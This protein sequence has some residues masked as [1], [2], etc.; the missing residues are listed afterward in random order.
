MPDQLQWLKPLEPFTCVTPVNEK[1]WQEVCMLCGESKD[2]DSV[3][4]AAR[5][6]G[7]K[8]L[9]VENAYPD[10]DQAS[11]A[12]YWPKAFPLPHTDVYRVHFFASE[13]GESFPAQAQREYLG[14]AVVSRPLGRLVRALMKPPPCLRST[15]G[16]DIAGSCSHC[17]RKLPGGAAFEGTVT[18]GV[19]NVELFGVEYVVEGVP[20]C[21]QDAWH[22]QC[23]HAAAWTCLFCGFLQGRV[24]RTT[25]ADAVE[26]G[27]TAEVDVQRGVSSTGTNYFQLQRIFT[28]RGMPALFYEIPSL[29]QDTRLELPGLRDG[30]RKHATQVVL[31]TVCNYLNS[32]FPVVASTREHTVTLIGWRRSC[33]PDDEIE[34]VYSDADQIFGTITA[35]RV[36][37]E[38]WTALMVPL[39]PEVVLTGE[40]AQAQAHQALQ[41][42]HDFVTGEVKE[43]AS[44]MTERAMDEIATLLA[45]EQLSLRLQLKRRHEYRAAIR[46]QASSRGGE[47]SQALAVLRLP[48]WV[49]VVEAQDRQARNR[50]EECVIAEFVFDTTSPDDAAHMAAVSIGDLTWCNW[51]YDPRSMPAVIRREGAPENLHW[52]SQINASKPPLRATVMSAPPGDEKAA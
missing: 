10:L 46:G 42:L 1:E 29:K 45:D 32:G 16:V 30:D 5:A 18:S 49:W 33:E 28:T 51:P 22:L 14:Y 20:Y 41:D 3:V 9:V 19:E 50:G 47:V 8:S 37:Q 11:E 36:Q 38:N 24:P 34:L 15:H 40:T 2:F 7:A 17:D 48:S 13:V 43:G 44:P 31:R 4:A 52:H 21:G 26:A 27:S 39:P 6:S 23:G 12:K 35:S 25:L